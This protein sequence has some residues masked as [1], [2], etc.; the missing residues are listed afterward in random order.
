M[1]FFATPKGPNEHQDSK[2]CSSGVR[3]LQKT[4]EGRGPA[5][6][7]KLDKLS[8]II[9]GLRDLVLDKLSKI[10]GF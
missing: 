9:K 10:I 3:A 4:Q 1:N 8:K 7:H 5:I 6:L 2:I